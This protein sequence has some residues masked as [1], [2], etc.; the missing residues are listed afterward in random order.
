[1]KP[2]FIPIFQED[3]HLQTWGDRFLTALMDDSGA[4]WERKIFWSLCTVHGFF[5]QNIN[6]SF[7]ELRNYLLEQ[8]SRSFPDAGFSHTTHTVGPK[9]EPVWNRCPFSC[10]SLASLSFPFPLENHAR[11]IDVNKEAI[12]TETKRV[13]Q[14]QLISPSKAGL[15]SYFCKP[16]QRSLSAFCLQSKLSHV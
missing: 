9:Q 5:A 13:R 16:E 3:T 14:L 4:T 10:L 6:I 8:C 12:Q 1:M 7:L 11:D 15:N 2:F